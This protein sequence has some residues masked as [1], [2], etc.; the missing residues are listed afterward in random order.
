MINAGTKIYGI[1]GNPVSHSLSPLLQNT[2]AN[3]MNIDMKYMA[4]HVKENIEDA[5]KG[6]FFFGYKGI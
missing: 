5:I 2:L 4:F 6:A 3:E 1:I